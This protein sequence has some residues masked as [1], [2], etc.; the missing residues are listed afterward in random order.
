MSAEIMKGKRLVW[1]KTSGAFV[2]P[3]L[4]RQR[5]VLTTVG[6]NKFLKGPV[7][8]EWMKSAAQLG[9][10]AFL[11]GM[12]IHYIAGS[13]LLDKGNRSHKPTGETLWG[14]PSR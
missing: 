2:E 5:Q 14:E 12:L 10:K 4:L 3:H 7:S 6:S 13:C 1:D 11:V 8:L 9:G